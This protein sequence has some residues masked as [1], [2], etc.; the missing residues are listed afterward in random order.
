M[1]RVTVNLNKPFR[2]Y[3]K[4]KTPKVCNQIAKT[5]LYGRR[6]GLMVSALDS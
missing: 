4:G 6:G 3:P 2:S 1:V 5:I